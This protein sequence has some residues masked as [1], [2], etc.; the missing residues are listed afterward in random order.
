MLKKLFRWNFTKDTGIAAAAGLIMIALSLLMIPFGG[1]T[2][3]DTLISF[4]LRD[5]LMIFGLG[6]VF[7]SLYIEKHGKETAEEIGFTKLKALL[8]LGVDLA[9][10]AALLAMFLKDEMPHNVL[11]LPNLYG[12]S[13]ILVAGIFEMTFIYGFLRMSFEKAFGIIPAI[14]LTSV[15]YSFHHAGFQPEFLHLFLVGLMYCSVFYITR[16]L[17]V[18]FPFFWGVGALWDVLVSS[19]AGNEIKNPT[20]FA[21]ALVILLISAIWIFY[22]KRRR[23]THAVK[24]LDR[25]HGHA[26]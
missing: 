4:L 10:A 8:S 26:Q 6:V 18:I 15:F 19:E 2:A 3:R 14:L 12:A 17:L 13:Y 11:T 1:N 20:S 21:I 22:Q 24:N 5:L 23:N 9:L 25:D 16:N 7:V